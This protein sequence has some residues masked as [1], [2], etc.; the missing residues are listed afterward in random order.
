MTVY[1]IEKKGLCCFIN[2]DND[3]VLRWFAAPISITSPYTQKSV[4][5][6]RLLHNYCYF[7]TGLEG[8]KFDF[9][10]KNYCKKWSFF[11]WHVVCSITLYSEQ[12]KDQSIKE[13]LLLFSWFRRW[14]CWNFNS[15][16]GKNW[17]F[18]TLRSTAH[19]ITLCTTVPKQ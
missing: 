8:R 10:E 9:C 7:M 17:G 14:K 12:L 19:S 6:E 11:F 15:N 4:A 3:V 5:A 13:T 1:W 16:Y 2:T 18:F